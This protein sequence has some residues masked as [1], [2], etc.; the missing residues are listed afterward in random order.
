M[1]GRFTIT[2]TGPEI[3][4]DNV[5][6]TPLQIVYEGKVKV[7]LLHVIFEGI[8]ALTNYI[9]LY[10]FTAKQTNNSNFNG[11]SSKPATLLAFGM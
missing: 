8:V 6:V 3:T 7:R 5:L 9:Y 4:S 10:V 11:K 1:T 2:N